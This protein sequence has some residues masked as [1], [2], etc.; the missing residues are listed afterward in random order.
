MDGFALDTEVTEA[1]VPELSAGGVGGA[2]AMWTSVTRLNEPFTPQGAVR[3]ESSSTTV[4]QSLEVPAR[5]WG[6]L[7][8]VGLGNEYE[9]DNDQATIAQCEV[10]SNFGMRRDLHSWR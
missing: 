8:I 4:E 5:R 1:R 3:R 9:D 2:P 7:S 10:T 6:G